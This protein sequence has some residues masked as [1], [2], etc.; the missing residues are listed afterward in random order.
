M[1]NTES[2]VFDLLVRD[3]ASAGLSNIGKAAGGAAKDTSVL[4]QR[5][6][7]LAR[8]SY[9]ARLRLAGDKESQAALDKF[10]ARMISIDHRVSSPNL[11]VEGAARAIAEISAVDLEMDKL[12]GKGGTAQ[13]AT[14]SLGMGGLS[15]PAGMAA[16]IGAGVALS[17]VIATVAIGLGGLAVGAAGTISPILKASQ[18]AGGL[19]ANMALLNPQQQLMARQLLTLE[20]NASGF[21]KSLQ[22]EVVKIWGDALG[23]AGGVLHDVEPVAK[24]AGDGLHQVMNALNMNFNSAEWQNFFTWMGQNAAPDVKLLGQNLIDLVNTL[25]GLLETL[26]PVATSLLTVLDGVLK[27]VHGLEVVK[28]LTSHA[29]D[30][31]ALLQAMNAMNGTGGAATVMGAAAAAAGPKVGTLSGDVAILGTTTSQST[32][33]LQAY[34]DLWNIF[35]GNTV[36]DQQAVLNVTQAFEAFGKTVQQSGRTST[37][38]QQAFLSIFTTIGTGLDALHKNGASVSQ[39]NSFYATSIARLSALHG[40]TPAQRQDVQGLTKD[41]LAWANSVTG[42]SGNTVKA[43]GVIRNDWLTTMSLT[44]KLVPVAKA[45]ADAFA[46]SVLKTGTNSRATKHDRDVLIADLVHSGLSAQAAQ[47]LVI[48]F[49]GQI[50]KLKGKTVPIGATFSGAGKITAS[51]SMTGGQVQTVGNL[52]FVAEGGIV[53]GGYSRTDNHLA[54]LRSGEGVLQP[55]AV[56]ALGGAPF[57]H[58][59]NALYGDVPVS[60]YAAGGLVGMEAGMAGISPFGGR[61]DAHF[62]AFAGQAFGKA[63]ETAFAAAAA[64]I[65]GANAGGRFIGVGSP[66]GSGPA[67]FAQVAARMGWGP[68]ELAAW[69][70]VEM[71]EAGYNLNAVNPSSGAAGMAQF[72]NGFGE[73]AQWGGNATTYIGQATAM[74]NYIRSRYGDPIRAA[75]HE[76]AF[77]WYGGGLDAVFDRPTVIGVGER[78]RER[79]TVTPAGH[80]GDTY[81]YNMTITLPPGSDREQ[82][83]RIVEYVQSY[84]RGSGKGWRS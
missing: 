82:G 28:T 5:L 33:A 80:G 61:M 50:D 74:A 58:R 20:G 59:A 24:G 13:T 1:P 10:D 42:L 75:Q 71:R 21:A 70:Y 56:A 48:G 39:L 7:D 51:Q 18:A 47:A 43:A 77:N 68:A 19:A 62:G 52:L 63:A 83:R 15:G 60:H 16:L 76:A 14:A 40:L 53:P 22:P 29:G 31:V 3:H 9:E 55:G 81:V 67:A 72:I 23:I 25:P 32:T 27:V 12:G 35:V 79:V 49:Q 44:H 73:Y 66:A 69:N 26:Q 17:P 6:N 4:Q 37:A 30:P 36:G 8:K 2:L 46:S 11:K 64:V 54:M 45:D 38:A 65:T 34:S 84:E 41:Y 57:I 78:G